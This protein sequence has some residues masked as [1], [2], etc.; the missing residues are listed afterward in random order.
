MTEEVLL[1]YH[2]VLHAISAP[3]W[4]ADNNAA[5]KTLSLS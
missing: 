2:C 3:F 5:Y 4:S 1:P